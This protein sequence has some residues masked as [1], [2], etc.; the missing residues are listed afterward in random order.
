MWHIETDYFAA[1]VF[2]VMI[3]KN[4]RFRG[5]DLIRN[6]AFLALLILGI[7][8][9]AL[10]IVA[11][12]AMNG[13]GDWWFY[14][15]SMTLY[16]ATQVVPTVAWISYMFTVIYQ[17]E[18]SITKRRIQLLTIPID[19]VCAI[20]LTNPLNGLFFSLGPDMTYARGPLFIPLGFGLYALYA[21]AGFFI[22]LFNR[23]HIQPRSNV[24]LMASFFVISL[25]AILV[26]LANPGW[27]ITQASYAV[28]CVLC[29]ATIEE[30]NRKRLFRQIKEQNE[31]L[32]VAMDK[33]KE[34]NRA[35]DDFFSRVSHDMRTPMNGILG[36][37]SLAL[38]EDDPAQV[39]RDV[40][41]IKE[42]GEYMLS[43]IN[44]T[45]DIQR[46]ESGNL[47]LDL[48]VVDG[49]E[50]VDSVIDM[51]RPTAEAKGVH[52][53]VDNVNAKLAFPTRVDPVRVK[54]I[55]VNLLSNAVK[56]TPEGGT[57]TLRIECLS[58]EGDL[59]HDRFQVCD[60][61]V[62]MSE[63]FVAEG[64]FKPFSQE[65]NSMTGQYAGSGLG[66]S[67]VKNLVDKMGGRI[68]VESTQGKGTTF[69]VYLDLRYMDP[70]TV[71]DQ[72]PKGPPAV[73][74]V[75]APSGCTVLLCEDNALNAEIATRLLV[76]EGY[77]VELAH[78]GLEG[79]D[80]FE[81]SPEGTI[82][83][84]LMDIRMPTMDGLEATARIRALDRADAENVPV[85][86]MTANAFD[87]DRNHALS[88]GMS[89]FI[90]KPIDPDKLFETLADQ[91]GRA[92]AQPHA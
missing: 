39:K 14:E 25:T 64:L 11:S 49:K 90:S 10:D 84:V 19:I 27:L 2:V 52:F 40:A 50:L 80:L 74:H 36:M 46:S 58:Q 66:L 4:R 55:F 15:I 20:A 56:F 37:A 13:V 77:S 34:A 83:A 87:E 5:D 82:S 42:S 54:Q 51:T 47:N 48:R 73:R 26:Q 86:A 79:V 1:M 59:F 12:M 62:G 23:K 28:S 53:V 35:R 30:R 24:Y 9:T 67:I 8:T 3:I 76:K 33:V 92:G 18:W 78:D 60:T 17:E 41:K 43:L 57:V 75:S 85:I 61:G 89:G 32:V 71:L 16:A 45:L 70:T 91:I 21:V 81:R 63:Q 31:S 6:R 44:D 29:D 38:E 69:S 22:L 7:A 72:E 68:E 65:P 88:A